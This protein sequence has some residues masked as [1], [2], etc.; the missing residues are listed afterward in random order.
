MIV[1]ASYTGFVAKENVSVSHYSLMDAKM[2]RWVKSRLDEMEKAQLPDV[3]TRFLLNI[4]GFRWRIVN[5]AYFNIEGKSYFVDLFCPLLCLVFQ[6]V[7]QKM[8]REQKAAARDRNAALESIGL[9]IVQ[10]TYPEMMSKDFREGIFSPRVKAAL[11]GRKQESKPAESPTPQVPPAPKKTQNCLLLEGV[12]DVVRQVPEG[13]LAVIATP[14]IYVI[15]VASRRRLESGKTPNAEVL[16]QLYAAKKGRF[17]YFYFSGNRE[18]GIRNNRR[19]WAIVEHWDGKCADVPEG[20]QTYA[21]DFLGGAVVTKA[22][23]FGEFLASRV[24]NS[25]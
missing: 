17:V 5:H 1:Y 7:S 21:I 22:T 9:T 24:V 19:Q 12:R 8:S 15:D 6:I 13:A 16:S 14:F 23:T 2:A 25:K 4:E 18:G 11:T 20:T 3:K 10:F